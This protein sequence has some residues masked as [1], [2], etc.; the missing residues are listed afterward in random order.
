MAIA[1][2]VSLA[3]F[4][5]MLEIVEASF[6]L[7]DNHNIASTQGGELITSAYGVR[8]WSGTV[9]TR[10]LPHASAELIAARMRMIANARATF[11]VEPIHHTLAGATGAQINNVTNGYEVKFQGLAANK[12]IPAGTFFSYAYDGTRR[13]FHQTIENGGADG[14]GLTGFIQ[15][16]PEI[17]PGWAAGAAVAFDAP[18]AKAVYVP[19]SLRS[20]VVR[21]TLSD[22]PSFDWMQTLRKN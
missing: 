4:F 12:I 16:E 20:P 13:A 18:I 10:T 8:L 19:K 14:T 15:V 21:A 7:G 2:P 11:Y 17:R 5:D 3:N 6:H 9:R 1:F 22:G